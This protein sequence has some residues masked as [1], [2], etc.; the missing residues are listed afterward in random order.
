MSLRK[1]STMTEESIAARQANARQS[2]GPATPAGRERIRAA[3]TR[4]GFY[5]QAEAT[6]LTCLGEDPAD[7][8]RLRR[9]LQDDL[10]P[11][12]PLEKELAEHLAQVVWR[13]RRASRMQEGFALRLAKD[14]NLTREDR[15]HAQ[16]MRLKITAETLRRLALSVAREDYVTPREDLEIMKNLHQ[17]GAVKEIGEVA[18]ALFYQ[19]QAPGTDANG[20]DPDEQSRRALVRIK[21]IFGLNGDHPPNVTRVP[22]EPQEGQQVQTQFRC[23]SDQRTSE[24]GDAGPTE[25]GAPP[26][27]SLPPA[28]QEGAGATRA[29]TKM[30]R[31]RFTPAEWEA[32]ERPRQLL[33]NI[34]TRQLELCE[35]QRKAILKDSLAGPSPY[36][37]AAEVGLAHPNVA[38]M[39]RMEESSF[40]QIWR[41]TNLLLKLKRQAREERPEDI[42]SRTWN[43][44]EKAAA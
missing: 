27:S 43:V 14:A 39:Q 40:R 15:L 35:A 10:Q 33:E 11:P 41:I 13:W 19:L 20:V 29:A 23:E 37:R 8:E 17:E 31:S 18:L 7:L 16:M 36:E 9:N 26:A 21:A 22:I 4:H 12:S 6:A 28:R 24:T 42:P 32:R 1:K 5:S 44:D 38:L 30:P 3:N 25:A 34:L 2:R